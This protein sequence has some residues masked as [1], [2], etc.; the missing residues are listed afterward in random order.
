MHTILATDVH[1][2]KGNQIKSYDVRI[3]EFIH[4]LNI[5]FYVDVYFKV[6]QRTNIIITATLDLPYTPM[7]HVYHIAFNPLYHIMTSLFLIRTMS[8]QERAISIS[9]LCEKLKAM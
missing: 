7:K 8:K 3:Y 6:N 9:L 2:Q 5:Y 4:I 1:K